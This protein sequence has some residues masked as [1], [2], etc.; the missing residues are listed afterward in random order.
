M[1]SHELF[2]LA[3]AL[4]VDKY[5]DFIDVYAG[6]RP[7]ERETIYREIIEYKETAM[8]AQYIKEEVGRKAGVRVGRKP[9]EKTSLRFSKCVSTQSRTKSSN[10]SIA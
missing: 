6:V 4:L 2:R 5:V 7:V 10:E 9:R 3:S 8:L 1:P